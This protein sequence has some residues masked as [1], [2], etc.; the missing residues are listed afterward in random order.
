MVQ[1]KFSYT[2]EDNRNN[3]VLDD[4]EKILIKINIDRDEQ[5]KRGRKIE[6]SVGWFTIDEA[7]NMIVALENAVYKAKK[8]IE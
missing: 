3:Q 1:R 5:T 4:D 2:I 7:T 6:S 8:V